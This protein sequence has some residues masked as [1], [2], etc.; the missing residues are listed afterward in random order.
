V[1][2]GSSRFKS[3]M[4]QELGVDVAPRLQTVKVEEP[5]KRKGGIIVHSVE[6]LVDKLRN[7]AKVL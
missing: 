1:T 2:Q 7:E 3:V 4:L 5:P 6:E